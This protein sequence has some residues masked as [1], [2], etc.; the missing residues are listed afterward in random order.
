[1]NYYMPFRR[2]SGGF[3]GYTSGIHRLNRYAHRFGQRRRRWRGLRRGLTSDPRILWAQ[4]CL[5]KVV[6]PSVPQDGMLGPQT[7]QAI[8]SF[9]SQQQLPPT[10]RL[11]NNTVTALQQACSAQ[12]QSGPGATQGPP[13]PAPQMTASVQAG[14]APG[15]QEMEEGEEEEEYRIVRPTMRRASEYY[16]PGRFGRSVGRW[17]WN[18]ALPPWRFRR[19]AVYGVEGDQ[20]K[21]YW[22]QSCLTQVLGTYVPQNGILNTQTQQAIQQ[23]QTQQQLP[24]TGFLDDATIGALQA[25]CSSSAGSSNEME[26]NEYESESE[27]PETDTRGGRWIRKRGRIVLLD[28]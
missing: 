5:A 13:S 11:D 12:A 27:G 1:M 10:G 6:D 22:A 16:A 17:Y 20:P 4:S 21:V 9:Q 26:E 15:Q 19:Y 14:A 18:R 28:V 24:P 8:S 2:Y 3:H 23:F 25:A 7:Q